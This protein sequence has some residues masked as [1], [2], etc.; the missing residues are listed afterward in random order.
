MITLRNHEQKNNT[1][2][3]VEENQFQLFKKIFY[4]QLKQGKI[5]ELDSIKNIVSEYI[6]DINDSSGDFDDE[7]TWYE[8]IVNQKFIHDIIDKHTFFEIIFH[9]VNSIQVNGK[10]KTFMKINPGLSANEF[11]TSLEVLALKEK[12]HWNYSN[13]F[14]SFTMKTTQQQFRIT[15]IHESTSPN[16]QCKVFYRSSS[17]TVPKISNFKLEK[18]EEKFIQSLI[19]SKQNII[20]SGAT[21][22][23]KSTFLKSLIN[24]VP[25]NEHIII[26]EDTHELESKRENITYLLENKNQ[27]TKTLKEYCAY[28]MR[29]DPDRIILGEVRSHEVVPFILAMNTGH[30]GLISTIHANNAIE[31][32][33]RLALLFS[34]YSE[35]DIT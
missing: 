9:S 20:I 12:I 24:F 28:A 34:L 31:T 13:P 7:K 17:K 1:L 11:K 30:K 15:L 6:D 32:I 3:L 14:A 21:S 18:K 19:P 2:K 29:M 5:L 26:L 27:K 35:T 4:D 33:D 22:S 8:N 23:G 10:D 25:K 16:N